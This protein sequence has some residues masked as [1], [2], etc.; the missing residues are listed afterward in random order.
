METHAAS[1]DEDTFVAERSERAT[2]SNMQGRVERVV[3]RKRNNGNIRLRE[4]DLE[5]NEYAVIVSAAWIRRR[6]QTCAM[7]QC[8]HA[9]R[10]FR[11]ARRRPGQLVGIGGEAGVVVDQ[12]GLGRSVDRE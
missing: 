9:S 10:E 11:V 2:S 1:D 6:G 12:L 5:G 7:E 8:G 4:N 3:E